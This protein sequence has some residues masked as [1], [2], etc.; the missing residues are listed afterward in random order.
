MSISA[1]DEQVLQH[2]IMY[3]SQV[4]KTIESLEI[5]PSNFRENFIYRNAVSM[6]LLQISM[7]FL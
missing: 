2:I 3:C 6:P 1:R 4:E 7:P 5:T